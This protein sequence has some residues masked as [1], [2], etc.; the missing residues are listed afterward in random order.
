[1]VRNFKGVVKVEDVKAEFDA[2]LD[3]INAKIDTYNDAL[4]MGE[5]VDYNNGG[6]DL[7]AYGYTLSVGGLK[8]VLEA[9][10]GA[11][12]GAKILKISNGQYVVS[13]GLYIKDNTVNRLP[14][15]AL[16]GDGNKVYYNEDNNQYTFEAQGEGRLYPN[17]NNNIVCVPGIYPLTIYDEDYNI[18][19]TAVTFNSPQVA[20][21]YISN[22][23]TNRMQNSIGKMTVY[24]NLSQQYDYPSLTPD[25]LIDPTTP[26]YSDVYVDTW[27]N[28]RYENV[29]G[30]PN[31]NR[32][33]FSTLIASNP[34]MGST[35]IYGFKIELTSTDENFAPSQTIYLTKRGTDSGSTT[36]GLYR[37][38][39][40][41]F[42]YDEND[43]LISSGNIS[44]G[45]LY[46]SSATISGLNSSVK[47]LVLCAVRGYGN[48]VSDN[49]I[50]TYAN[51]VMEIYKNIDVPCS[52]AYYEASDVYIIEYYNEG[53]NSLLG[54]AHFASN[55]NLLEYITLE[56][57]G[58]ITVGNIPISSINSN[59]ISRLCN[60][61]NATNEEIPDYKVTI[62]S[63]ANDWSS[64]R[65][66]MNPD[67][68]TKGIFY[69]GSAG[70]NCR[71]NLFD[72]QV[73]YHQWHGDRTD[74]YWEPFN[75]MFIPKGISNPYNSL[76][77]ET[78]FANQKFWNY[79][80][81]RPE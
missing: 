14:S 73:A 11:I 70:R 75:F 28:V 24:A 64:G 80:L 77:G 66:N 65:A 29:I 17:A 57:G 22:I 31:E 81:Q 62:E 76:A 34:N 69:N 33:S 6:E 78:I 60:R 35:H 2:L 58:G 37:W 4:D 71:I 26:Q 46:S 68:S 56:N 5:D 1:M 74:S 19:N 61:P 41:L 63:K 9:Y 16:Y 39:L 40:Q 36:Q 12:L 47:K 20:A 18:T 7:A 43:N 79:I 51:P 10:D 23:T 49:I 21:K 3:A 32:N 50:M 72:T 59:R 27:S 53:S 54:S 48:F 42:A 13:E 67:T 55:S 38:K 44:E 25:C 52:L 8:K 15:K 45:G 30:T